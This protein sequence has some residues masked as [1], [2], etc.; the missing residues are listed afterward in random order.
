MTAPVR[1]ITISDIERNN[2]G[3]YLDDR[4]SVYHG[5]KGDVDFG[6]DGLSAFYF[7][8][9]SYLLVLNGRAQVVVDQREYVLTRHTLF[10]AS[11]SHLVKYVS[12]SGDFE[13]CAMALSIAMVDALPLVNIKPRIL[14]GMRGHIHPVSIL[15]KDDAA[16]LQECFF[17]VRKQIQRTKHKYRMQLIE[18]ALCKFFYEYDNIQTSASVGTETQE[19]SARQTEIVDRFVEMATNNVGQHND[20]SFYCNELNVSPQYLTR[21][22]KKITGVRPSDFINEML[23]AEARNMLAHTDIPIADIAERLGFADQSSFGKFYKRCS[24]MRPSDFRRNRGL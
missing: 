17:D 12:V 22:T 18:N 2:R 19:V 21:L 6:I 4:L 23:Y 1:V 15:S 10:R 9:F 13:Y 3:D 24:G 20:V 11:P 8:T 16:L 5:V 14:E 7:K